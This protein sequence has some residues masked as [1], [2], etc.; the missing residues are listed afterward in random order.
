M[1][2][3][4][5]TLVEYLQ[6]TC[7]MFK[8]ARYEREGNSHKNESYKCNLV[9]FIRN[10]NKIKNMLFDEHNYNIR[11]I[12]LFISYRIELAMSN[13]MLRNSNVKNKFSILE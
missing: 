13:N 10:I 11:Y 6:Y 4:G 7:G 5:T 12:N 3:I 9:I 1:V 2:G 8:I